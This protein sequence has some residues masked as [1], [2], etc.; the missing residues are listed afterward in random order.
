MSNQ[1]VRR[2]TLYAIGLGPGDP[3]LLTVKAVKIL[4]KADAII[5]PKARIKTESI[6]RDIVSRALGTDLPFVEQIFPMSRDREDLERHWKEAARTVLVRLNGG[7]DVAFVTLGDVS[8]YSTFSYMERTLRSLDPS[9]KPVL[10]PGISSIQL[11][12][13][14]FEQ[15][16]ALGDESYGVYPLPDNLEDL[17][18]A[19]REHDTVM[20]MKIGQRLE[21]VKEYLD[22]KGLMGRTGFVRRAGFPDEFLAQSLYDL[23]PDETGYLSILMVRTGRND[24]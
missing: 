5:V 16:L 23:S 12:A 24:T 4:K 9:V 19:L 11:A 2:G 14:R 8:L 15:P 7:E 1:T 3:D 6:A 17:D 13:V 21:E 10:V 18:S 20:L 22:G